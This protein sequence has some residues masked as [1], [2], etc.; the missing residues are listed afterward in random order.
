M[1][2]V[3]LSCSD[4]VFRVPKDTSFRIAASIFFAET[5]LTILAISGSGLDRVDCPKQLAAINRKTAAKK[6]AVRF[7]FFFIFIGMRYIFTAKLLVSANPASAFAPVFRL[8]IEGKF[9]RLINSSERLHSFLK[10]LARPGGY[11]L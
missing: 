4:N 11:L 2:R 7:I 8:P 9:F 3:G 6:Y 5:S 1:P 10:S